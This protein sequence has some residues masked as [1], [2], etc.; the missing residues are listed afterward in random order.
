[1][2]TIEVTRFRVQSEREHELVQARGEMID[3]FVA[4]RDGFLGA[5]LV[6]LGNGEWLDLVLWDGPDA[7][8]ASRERGANR[9]GIEAFFAAISTLVSMEE[10]EIIHTYDGP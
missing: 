6:R 9:P 2:A 10:G 7:F 8:A 4:D 1:M 3:D 5:T